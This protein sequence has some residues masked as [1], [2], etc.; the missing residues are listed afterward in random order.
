MSSDRRKIRQT[1]MLPNL[2]SVLPPTL[3]LC[4][5]TVVSR[6]SGLLDED[7]IEPFYRHHSFVGLQETAM[8]AVQH[9]LCVAPKKVDESSSHCGRTYIYPS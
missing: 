2:P 5:A 4:C 3:S 8:I 9:K 1:G 7:Y 6:Y